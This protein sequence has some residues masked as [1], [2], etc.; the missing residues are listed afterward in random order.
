[1]IILVLLIRRIAALVQ[2]TVHAPQVRLA[3]II[4]VLPGLQLRNVATMSA[5]LEWRIAALVQETVLVH[6]ELL[7][8]TTNVLPEVR[9]LHV[10]P[11]TVV[12]IL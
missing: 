2:E 12:I 1:M 7:V 8:R 4:N 6:P 11:H 10:T 5:L 9:I 3:R